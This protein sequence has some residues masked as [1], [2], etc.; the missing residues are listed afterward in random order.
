MLKRHRA[1]AL[2][3]NPCLRI[4]LNNRFIVPPCQ[5]LFSDATADYQRRQF[6]TWLSQDKKQ[7]GC[8]VIPTLRSQTR[9]PGCFDQ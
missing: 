2:Q 1:T 4:A 3:V 7:P 6:S 9:Q 8:A 5:N